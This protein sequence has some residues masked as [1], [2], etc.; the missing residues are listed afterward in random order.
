MRGKRL[1][2]GL[3][4]VLAVAVI[5]ILI[6][7]VFFK[8]ADPQL[9]HYGP[10]TPF[11]FTDERGQP[12][13]QEM[14]LGHVTIVSF[15]FTRCDLACPVTSMKMERLQEKTFDVGK[16]VKLASFTVDPAFDTPPILAAY[17]QRYHADP[18][19]WR[20]LTGPAPE[21]HQLV[22]GSFM[23]T[24]D[25][26]GLSPHGVISIAHSERFFLVDGNGEIRGLY[27]SGDIQ[28]LDQLVHDARFL[29][30]TQHLQ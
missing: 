30:R 1:L 9:D 2:L 6:P 25:P 12:I 28:K 13:T 4:G 19:R 3:L 15:I 14:F 18:T 17:A 23:S 22:E 7:M 8:T 26:N 27:D 5:V 11:H 16:A 10:V 20:F 21:L 29:V 24:M